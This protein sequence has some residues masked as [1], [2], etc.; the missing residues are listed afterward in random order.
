MKPRTIKRFVMQ[1]VVDSIYCR[2]ITTIYRIVCE[3]FTKSVKTVDTIN[4][5]IIRTNPYSINWCH[6]NF[7]VVS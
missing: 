7:M 6:V 4:K 2:F 5:Q 3:L 1:S